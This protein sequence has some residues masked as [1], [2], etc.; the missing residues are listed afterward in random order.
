MTIELTLLGTI[1]GVT[2]NHEDSAW[3]C[4]RDMVI[5]LYVFGGY[6][7]AQFLYDLYY[8]IGFGYINRVSEICRFISDGVMFFILYG[9]AIAWLIYGNVLVYNAAYTCR[10]DNYSGAE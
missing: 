9:F 8:T 5:W 6:L 10:Y 1:Y 7:G 4:S 3:A 2:N